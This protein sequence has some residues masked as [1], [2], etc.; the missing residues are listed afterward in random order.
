MRYH[1]FQKFCGKMVKIKETAF[2]SM[3]GAVCFALNCILN[4]TEKPFSLQDNEKTDNN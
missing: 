1:L 3:R 4:K 2:L